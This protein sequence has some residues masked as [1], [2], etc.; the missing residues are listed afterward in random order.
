[1]NSPSTKTKSDFLRDWNDIRFFLAAGRAGSLNA[2][3]KNLGTSQPTVGR[4]IA[5]LEAVLGTGLFDR[6]KE[7]LTLTKAG[8]ALWGRALAME[9]AAHAVDR[10]ILAQDDT[11]AGAVRL[12]T[13]EGLG[14]LW[15]TPRLN[16]LAAAHP[17]LTI[18][19]L[20]DNDAADLLRRE[21]DVAIRLARPI[22]P[23]LIARRVGELA[24]QLFASR[25]YVGRNGTPTGIDQLQAHR[26]VAV[27]QRESMLDDTWQQ[28]LDAGIRVAY[29]SNSSLAQV[30]AVQAGIGI[31]LLPAYVGQVLPS[32][33]PILSPGLWRRREI[34]L[35]A[36]PEVRNSGRVRVVFD[37]MVRLFQAGAE[38]LCCASEP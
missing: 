18:E 21:A 5:A 14:T 37:E 24:F 11:M 9:E 4:R 19:L 3:A 26:L 34:W 30:A 6:H 17:A 7:G 23:N 22:T 38:E 1:M 27:A 20:V 25:D 10:E 28:V 15:L 2:A 35:V 13:T 32:V 31:G 33:V 12:S 36:H 29:R 8:Q 16:A